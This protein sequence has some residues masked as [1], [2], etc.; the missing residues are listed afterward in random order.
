MAPHVRQ[1]I[2]A[3]DGATLVR[4]EDRFGHFEHEPA[5]A[6]DMAPEALEYHRFAMDRLS[7]VV[8]SGTDKKLA[9]KA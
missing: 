4:G 8:M 2:A 3:T 9:D 7:R 1:T 5:P 6:R